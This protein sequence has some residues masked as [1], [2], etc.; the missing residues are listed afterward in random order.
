MSEYTIKRI[1]NRG[2]NRNL[3]TNIYSSVITIVKA[4]T[5]QMYISTE[6]WIRKYTMYIQKNIIQP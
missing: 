1:K 6:E 3:Y 2:S 5:A 4:K